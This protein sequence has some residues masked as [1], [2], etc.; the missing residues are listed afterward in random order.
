MNR[1]QL[2]AAE[3]FH[4]SYDNY[5]DHLG[6]NQRFDRLMPDDVK[7]LEKATDEKWPLNSIAEELDV[8]PETAKN[9]FESFERARLIVD[10]K[11]PAESFRIG[12]RFSIK[13]AVAAGLQDDKAI[14]TLVTQI[15]YRAADLG[16]LLKQENRQLSEFSDDLRRELD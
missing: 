11:N 13:D 16:Y 2:L 5:D 14:E 1:I 9:L 7:T 12:V 6:V 15:C 4:Y 8:D 3:T 10:A